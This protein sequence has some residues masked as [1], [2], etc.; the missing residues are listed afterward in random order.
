MTTEDDFQSAL[1]ADPEDGQTR[2]VFADWLEERGDPRADGYRAMGRLGLRAPP[3]T[4]ESSG[5]CPWFDSARCVVGSGGEAP[6]HCWLPSDWFALLSGGVQTV[7]GHPLDTKTFA[8]Y[9]G[10]WLDWFSRREAEDAAA[11]AFARLPPERRAELL[12]VPP[13]EP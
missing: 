9:V 1:D 5:A 7:D 11:K 6:V 8:S 2:L 3:S 12:A 10:K 4:T 13:N